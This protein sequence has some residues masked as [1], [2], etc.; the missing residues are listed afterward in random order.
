MEEKLHV[1]NNESGKIYIFVLYE[2]SIINFPRSFLSNKNEMGKVYIII[3]L[4]FCLSCVGEKGKIKMV[5]YVKL[6]SVDSFAD[7][8]FLSQ[9]KNLQV[10][11]GNLYFSDNYLSQIF[12]VDKNFN[13]YCI[14]GNHGE[15]PN[16]F[17]ALRTLTVVDDSIYAFD[18]GHYSLFVYDLDGLNCKKYDFSNYSIYPAYRF[19]I[20]ENHC[21]V[22][23]RGK[24]G[25]LMDIDLLSKQTYIW[26]DLISFGH[27][28]QERIRNNRNIFIYKKSYILVSNNIPVVE[29]Y[30][31]YNKQI[32]KTFDYSDI[33]VIRNVLIENDNNLDM[34]SYH[35][36]VQDAYVNGEKLYILM[37]GNN[38]D[39]GYNVNKILEISLS[40]NNEINQII[41]LPGKVYES[42]CVDNDTIYAFNGQNSSIE[43]LVRE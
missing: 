11:K 15:G 32:V 12:E 42:F 26:G 2:R 18:A 36:V 41:Q 39:D 4:L 19:V 21:Q 25:V 33:D 10:Y 38:P 8:I 22:Q 29:F 23:Y 13:R 28:K 6:S 7:S 20:D 9:V 30:D 35:I 5:R 40:G 1:I 43:L 17:V 27:E 31:R 24:E 3:C 34:N 37:N 16:D 14:M